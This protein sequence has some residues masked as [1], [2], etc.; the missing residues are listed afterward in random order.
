MKV[1]QGLFMLTNI[2]YLSKFLRSMNK[3]SITADISQTKWTGR[4]REV[5]IKQ[6]VAE[7]RPGADNQVFSLCGLLTNA[8]NT[9]SHY[10]ITVP[11]CNSVFPIIE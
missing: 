6:Q 8:F 7:R 10:T 11:L 4:I 9:V 3:W 1:M 5:F 2:V